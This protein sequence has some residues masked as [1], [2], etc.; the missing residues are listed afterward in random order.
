MMVP[1]FS[2][3]GSFTATL[4]FT[5]SAS[6]TGSQTWAFVVD[7]FLV[8]PARYAYPIDSGDASNK[9]FNGKVPR[10]TYRMTSKGR[11]ALDGYWTA[12]DSIRN[13]ASE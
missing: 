8:I 12:L 7:D 3:S 10:T 6:N 4:S 13:G 1:L 9:G 5:D 2:G 11:A